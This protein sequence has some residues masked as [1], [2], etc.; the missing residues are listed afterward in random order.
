MEEKDITQNVV[1]IEKHGLVATDM[2]VDE[3]DN[4]NTNVDETSFEDENRSKEPTE[5]ELKG[6]KIKLI[7]SLHFKYKPKK[8]FGSAFKA[9]R[10]RK[11]Q[12]VKASRKNNRKK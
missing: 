12:L 5:E 3:L 11:Q 1:N 4:V 9:K 6:M 7:Q 8:N 2:V 10:K